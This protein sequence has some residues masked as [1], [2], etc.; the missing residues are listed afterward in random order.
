MHTNRT[1]VA[2]PA[3]CCAVQAG[4]SPPGVGLSAEGSLS[5]C[6]PPRPFSH[7]LSEFSLSTCLLL[8]LF[9]ALYGLSVKGSQN[10]NSLL[11]VNE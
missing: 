1:R 9:V 5:L 7:H 3:L 4:G 10:Q 11:E 8:R 2:L 6:P